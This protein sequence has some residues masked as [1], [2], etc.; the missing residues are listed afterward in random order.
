MAKRA[1]KGKAGGGP[2]DEALDAVYL[3]DFEGFVARRNE[4]AKRLRADGDADAAQAVRALK[5]PSRIAWA[6][7]LFGEREGQLSRELLEAGAALREA[8]ARL[9]AGD[10]EPVE[11]RSAAEGEQA[12]VNGALDAVAALAEEAGAPLSASA[13]ERVRQT[14]HAV[15]LDEAVRAD[16]E[17]R[18][19][20]TEH[21]AR[22]LGGLGAGSGPQPGKGD[23]RAGRAE[24]K[25]HQ[26]ARRQREAVRAAENDA[27]AA[28]QREEAARREVEGARK[29]AEAAEQDLVRA[30]K[31]LEAAER[32]A[33]KAGRTLD[34][35]RDRSG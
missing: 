7:N 8:Q 30:K 12:A 5:K 32:E 14:L 18:R 17:R 33:K 22:G 1:A 24:G 28:Q 35:L 27:A 31:A 4:L 26:K 19:L 13:V 23:G 16:F 29:R 6:I 34:E 20:S 25:G 9:M 3:G 2:A 11:L 21:E 15:S 10:A